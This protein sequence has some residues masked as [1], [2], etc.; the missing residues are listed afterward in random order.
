MWTL[1]PG[2]KLALYLLSFAKS[3]RLQLVDFGGEVLPDVLLE[4]E[5]RRFASPD[6]PVPL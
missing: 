5:E 2:E 1:H 3:N 6:E 4:S